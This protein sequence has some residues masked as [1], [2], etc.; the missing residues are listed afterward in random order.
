MGYD[1]RY[2]LINSAHHGVP[3][4]RDRVFMML[5][6]RHSVHRSGFRAATHRCDLPFGYGG[7]RSVALKLI[8]LFGGG[9]YVAPDTGGPEFPRRSRLRRRSAICRPSR[10]TGRKLRRGARR[11]TE[12]ARYR[13]IAP[14][15][16][17][18]FAREMRSW[19][20]FEAGEGV[21]D[22]VLRYLPRDTIIFEAMQQGDEYPAAH[23]VANRL[24][25]EEARRQRIHARQRRMEA[26]PPRHGATL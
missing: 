5:F 16:F 4:M 9:A 11:F 1:A 20:G 13:E 7:T 15:S 14:G 26:P 2:S 25:E 10:S 24:F 21:Y 22:H 23:R 8:D 17:P 6:T 3:Q 18:T 12:L 19:P